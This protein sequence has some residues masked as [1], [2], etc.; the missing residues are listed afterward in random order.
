MPSVTNRDKLR[1]CRNIFCVEDFMNKYILVLVVLLVSGCGVMRSLPFTADS[2]N[3]QTA[4]RYFEQGRYDVAHDAY[5]AISESRSPW[6]EEAKFNAASV[7]V[8]YNNPR[9]NYTSAEGEFED[10]LFRYPQ[11]SLANEASTWLS[12]LKMFHQ[13]NVGILSKEVES[14]T[15]KGERLTKEMQQAQ[16]E[17]DSLKKEREV[18]LAEKA[19]LLKKV[20]YLLSEKDALIRKNEELVKDNEG[21][22]KDKQALTKR[23]DVLKK[24]K[25]VLSEAKATLEQSLRDLTMVDVKMERKRSKIKA[26][27]KK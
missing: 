19:I 14:L 16:Q 10:F 22:A 5:R 6:A 8:Y 4:K 3:Y 25:K 24:E 27:E 13:T 7:L 12:M 9:K 17:G 11:S 21:L 1:S 2:K 18:I 23:V 26:E 15:V 20:D